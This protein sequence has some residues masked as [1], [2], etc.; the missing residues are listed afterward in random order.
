VTLLAINEREIIEQLNK[1]PNETDIPSQLDHDLIVFFRK[2]GL[3][4]K[5]EPPY[6]KLFRNLLPYIAM[7]AVIAILLPLGLSQ[8]GHHSSIVRNKNGGVKELSNMK[9][10]VNKEYKISLQY[11]KSWKPNTQNGLSFGGESGF[12]QIS[13][14]SG[15]GVSIDDVTSAQVH[16]I[17][18]PFGSKPIVSQL[19]I[20]GQIARLIMPS[21]DQPKEYKNEAELIVRYPN[22]VSFNGDK[23]LYF[24]LYA[25]KV[26]IN[27]IAQSI[28]FLP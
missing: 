18:K 11:N 20:Q 9:N 23:Y 6:K 17:L 22:A 28:K 2:D 5:T 16:H 13:A 3:Q 26:N 15:E 12:F 14:I 7:I 19:T 1:L 8:L 21:S 4:T 27:A 25:D 24:V 10:Y